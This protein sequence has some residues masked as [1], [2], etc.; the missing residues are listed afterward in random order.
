M[1]G[2]YENKSLRNSTVFCGRGSPGNV[3]RQV[4]G[5]CEYGNE[6]SV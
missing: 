2:K 6:H 5:S 1:R 4:A 3:Y